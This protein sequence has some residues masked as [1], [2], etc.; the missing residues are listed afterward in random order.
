[1]SELNLILIG[2]PG[3]G[4]GTQA[5]HLTED[6][7]LPYLATGDMM[8]AKRK[9]D[10]ELG[11]KIDRIISEGG[12][13][14]DEV[15][16]TVLLERIEAEG[17]DGFLLDG[18]P[19]KASQADTLDQALERRGRE[20][21]AVLLIDVP[22]DVLVK[23]LSG[24]RVCEQGHVYHVE[25]NPP[26]QDG[27]CDIDGTPLVQRD[28]DRP[29]TIST[30]LGVYHRETEPLVDRYDDAGLLHRFDGTASPEDVHRHIRN[31]LS[32][33]KLEERL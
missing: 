22:D 18:F 20:I 17:D 4:K 28:D 12:L 9:E 10:S 19:R 21:T 1:M 11:R 30:R 15:V 14:D 6:F 23:R 3:A 31:T 25:T 8:R 24:R 2:P 27:V 5:S 32:T 13:V 16:C 33:L 26:K 7:G 29:E